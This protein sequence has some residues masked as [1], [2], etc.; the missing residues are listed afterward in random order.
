[1]KRYSTFWG[2]VAGALTALF[3]VLSIPP[4]EFAEAAYIAM[5]PLLLWFYT[6][7]KLLPAAVIVFLTGWGAW[8]T[9]LIWL[10]HVTLFGTLGLAAIL[11]VIFS[12]WALLVRWALPRLS[13][14]HI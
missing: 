9:I 8:F 2:I 13:L 7:P 14:I 11:A 3:W 1:M 5:V 10:R 6:R 4:C 12:G